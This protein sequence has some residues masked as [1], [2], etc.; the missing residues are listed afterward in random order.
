MYVEAGSR[1]TLLH[2]SVPGAEPAASRPPVEIPCS[3]RATLLRGNRNPAGPAFLGVSL[4][5]LGDVDAAGLDLFQGTFVV[6]ELPL[7][8]GPIV[9]LTK[10]SG[11]KSSGARILAERRAA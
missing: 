3:V 10:N 7:L 6:P 1:L 4:V 9:P 11:S 5:R 2:Q 8:D